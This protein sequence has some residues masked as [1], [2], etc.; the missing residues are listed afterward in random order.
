MSDEKSPPLRN[1]DPA[2]VPGFPT[3]SSNVVE[4]PAAPS[5]AAPEQ[6]RLSVRETKPTPEPRKRWR[7]ILALLVAVLVGVAA[8]WLLRRPPPIETRF[9]NFDDRDKHVLGPGW[10]H[11]EVPPTGDSMRWCAARSCKLFVQSRADAG[12]AIVIRVSPFRYPNAPPQTA[13]AF[14]NDVALDKHTLPDGMNVLSF[15]APIG[16]W[17]KGPNELRFEFAYADTP[18]NHAPDNPDARTL[19]AYFDWVEIAAP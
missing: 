19:S 7:A 12:H 15:A 16:L 3:T 1:E 2:P 13:Q 10:S 18:K 14:L 5:T 6:A 11:P 4:V 8:G 17:R 9:V